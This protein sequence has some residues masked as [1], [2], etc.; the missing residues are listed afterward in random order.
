MAT[1]KSVGPDFLFEIP[2]LSSS[3]ASE[4]IRLKEGA[5]EVGG[6]ACVPLHQAPIPPHTPNKTRMWHWRIC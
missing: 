2:F 4:N 5:K 1:E 6:P 3:P